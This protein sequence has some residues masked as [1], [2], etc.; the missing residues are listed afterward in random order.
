MLGVVQSFWRWLRG[1]LALV[2]HDLRAV[3]V[4]LFLAIMG[5][6]T[7]QGREIGVT[8]VPS[9][10]NSKD[11]WWWSCNLIVPSVAMGVWSALTAYWTWRLLAE[12]EARL[13]SGEL[14]GRAYQFAGHCYVL[15]AFLVP[16]YAVIPAIL[17]APRSSGVTIGLFG[18]L[19]VLVL[20]A[21]VTFFLLK[22]RDGRQAARRVAQVA[23][24]RP[25]FWLWRLVSGLFQIWSFLAFAVLFALFAG[26][27]GQ[28]SQFLTTPTVAFVFLAILVSLLGRI[29]RAG[30]R[31]GLPALSILVLWLLVGGY[32]NRDSFLVH[33]LEEHQGPFKRD[34]FEKW[35]AQYKDEE[36]LY[37]VATAGGGIRAAYWTAAVLSELENKHNELRRQV[38]AISS[39]SGGSLGA[40][41][42]I[43]KRSRRSE[44]VNR[45]ATEVLERDFLSAA[46]G[47]MFFAEVG[48]KLVMWR[49][50]P[51]KF[52]I[53]DRGDTLEMAWEHQ[54]A[55]VT[56]GGSINDRCRKPSYE[57]LTIAS[58]L[59][60]VWYCET[61]FRTEMPMLF[62]NSTDALTGKRVITSAV[63]A[64]GIYQDAFDFISIFNADVKLSTAVLNSA[65]FTLVSPSGNV[66]ANGKN[67]PLRIVDGGYFENY[68]AETALELLKKI[69]SSPGFESKIFNVIQIS[70]DPDL[71]LR[72]GKSDD[73]AHEDCASFSEPEYVDGASGDTLDTILFEVLLPVTAFARTREARGLLA[74]KR[75]RCFAKAE[76]MNYVHYRLD[77][78][79]EVPQPLGWM[80]SATTQDGMRRLAKERVREN[81]SGS[82]VSC[83][84]PICGYSWIQEKWQWLKSNL[85]GSS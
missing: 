72:M 31:L 54:W 20:A 41:A 49:D 57:D 47:G 66:P 4:V 19:V 75:L 83:K 68:G 9:D 12:R 22:L 84:K 51:G 78:V 10:E 5:L 16:P 33:G 59:M 11:I 17:S 2:F 30:D 67:G 81:L 60:E 63:D 61:G 7:S 82:Q 56:G 76:G 53:P 32:V 48:Q 26:W 42:W 77:C 44:S 39:V 23:G 18:F 85:G 58:S 65:R 79:D 25:R 29:C 74:A 73:P 8:M 45:V 28:A 24:A 46:L 55:Q 80:L 13:Q 38:I 71:T 34:D 37:I 1:L 43:L 69:R 62:A 15:L 6:T 50:W 52:T 27:P 35:I 21:L 70:S 3:T 14:A 36:E 40:A 64:K